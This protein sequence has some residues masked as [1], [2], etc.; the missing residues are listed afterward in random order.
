MKDNNRFWK[1]AVCTLFL[2]LSLPVRSDNNCFDERSDDSFCDVNNEAEATAQELDSPGYSASKTKIGGLSRVY[3]RKNVKRINGVKKNVLTQAML[4]SNNT[5]YVIKNDYTIGPIETKTITID[6]SKS[7]IINGE[8]YYYSAVN[9]PEGKTLR[10][11]DKDNCFILDGISSLLGCNRV[12]CI[13][14][15]QVIIGSKSPGTYYDA[16]SLE[17][18]ISIPANCTL[19]FEGGSISDGTIILNGAKIE[20]VG[21]IFN[22]VS[23]GCEYGLVVHTSWFGLTNEIDCSDV[24]ED[25]FDAIGH[26]LSQK[27]TLIIDTPLRIDKPIKYGRLLQYVRIIGKDYVN[28]AY[29]TIQ[30]NY[31][32]TSSNDN[33]LIK[34]Y[35]EG[36]EISNINFLWSPSGTSVATYLLEL[37]TN[38]TYINGHLSRGGEGDNQIHDCSFFISEGHSGSPLKLH[39]RGNQVCR[40][41]FNYDFSGDN[42]DKSGITFVGST[43]VSSTKTF[44][45]LP[46]YLRPINSQRGTIVSDCVFHSAGGYMARFEQDP[47]HND[48]PF[49]NAV[50]TNNY[51]NANSIGG[52]YSNSKIRGM[53]ISGNTIGCSND[54]SP[55]IFENDVDG[56]SIIGNSFLGTVNA[57]HGNSSICFIARERNHTFNSIIISNNLVDNV[58]TN[59]GSFVIVEGVGVKNRATVQNIN[60]TYNNFSSRAGTA[61]LVEARNADVYDANII[62][63]IRS[64]SIPTFERIIS[65]TDGTLQHLRILYNQGFTTGIRLPSKQAKKDVITDDDI[66]K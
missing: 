34:L 7:T 26:S 6:S 66:I 30:S 57:N 13:S 8:K 25:L 9:I 3:L 2:L 17:S 55:M 33:V 52:V 53:M 24:L 5:I 41:L 15:T 50:L 61:T 23:I 54:N 43:D 12:I 49:V 19:I 39:G 56:L 16:Y 36:V 32:P 20:N 65:I 45:E 21:E 27:T 58:E 4:N 18:I 11:V 46:A 31:V 28:L 35:S 48:V 14:F 29:P 40:C 60:L 10:L 62:G 47:S 63:N 42:I 22:N 64:N 59:T 44:A 37:N 1:I 51:S 38:N